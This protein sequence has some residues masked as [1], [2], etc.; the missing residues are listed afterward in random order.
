[1]HG[2][3]HPMDKTP[4]MWVQCKFQYCITSVKSLCPSA[5][6]GLGTL[7]SSLVLFDTDYHSL[8]LH[9]EPVCLVSVNTY[10]WCALCDDKEYNFF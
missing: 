6:A 4:P 7:F 8:A 5:Q 2:K 1:M 3:L 10:L 9:F